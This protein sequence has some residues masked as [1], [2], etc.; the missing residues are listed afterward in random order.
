MGSRRVPQEKPHVLNIPPYVHR[1]RRKGDRE[2]ERKQ[3]TKERKRNSSLVQT[4]WT[5]LDG[6]T[7]KRIVGTT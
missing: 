2:A 7:R 1:L 3:E 4:N 6:N 5:K